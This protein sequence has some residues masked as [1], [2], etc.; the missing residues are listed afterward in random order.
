L[1]KYEST[2][3]LHKNKKDIMELFLNIHKDCTKR[4]KYCSKEYTRL[5]DLKKHIVLDCYQSNKTLNNDNNEEKVNNIIH[6]NSIN[7]N[8]TTTH[9]IIQIIPIIPI[10]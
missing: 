7:N 2:S 5:D 10:I 8:S 4:C 3:L 9:S 6:D 1:K